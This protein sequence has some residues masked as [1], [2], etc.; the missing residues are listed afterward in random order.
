VISDEFAFEKF[1]RRPNFGIAQSLF[2][3][4]NETDIRLCLENLR[5]VAAPGCR[6]FATFVE[7]AEAAANPDQSHSH[8]RFEFTR[9]QMEGFGRDTGW[10]AH[11][12]GDWG[13]PRGQRMIEYR[14]G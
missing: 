4:L 1:D 14:A 6:F 12:I 10:Q 13:H 5:P 2:S 7:T 8:G 9:A 11:Y 3:H